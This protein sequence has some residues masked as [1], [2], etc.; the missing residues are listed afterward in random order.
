MHYERQ[1]AFLEFKGSYNINTKISV[2]VYFA[3]MIKRI[4]QK[5]ESSLT[6]PLALNNKRNNQILNAINEKK[7]RESA[8]YERAS[9]TTYTSR[10]T[11]EGAKDMLGDPAIL[12][13]QLVEFNINITEIDGFGHFWAQVSEPNFIAQV[14]SIQSELNSSRVK[15]EK[16][17]SQDLRIGKMIAALFID[18][19]TTFCRAKIVEVK[20]PKLYEIYYVDFGNSEVKVLYWSY[21]LAARE[22]EKYSASG[23]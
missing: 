1:R 21:I 7:T 16:I 19:D 23:L 17:D 20:S 5:T 9:T 8:R 13:G 3:L 22:F 6:I 12:F 18:S 2:G 14:E 11:V 4:H 10:V 15:L